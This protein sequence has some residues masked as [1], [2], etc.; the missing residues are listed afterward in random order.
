MRI[1]CLASAMLLALGIGRAWGQ[2]G[3]ATDMPVSVHPATAGHVLPPVKNRDAGGGPRKLWTRGFRVQGVGEHA[4]A[5]I[6]PA[7]M[8]TLAD[9]QFHKLAGEGAAAELS[10]AQLQGAA[11]AI[12]TTYRQAGFIVA[13]AYLPA[14]NVGADQI[15]EIRVLEGQ[16]GKVTVKGTKRYRPE[17][18]AAPAEHLRGRTL[19]KSDVDT[20][21]LYARDLPGIAVSSVLQPGE[22]DGETDLVM[23]ARETPRPYAISVGGNNY[24][25]SLTGRY[26]A[27]VGASWYS[28]LGL[29]DVLSGTYAY[30]LDPRQSHLG[31][32]SY[33]VPTV[34]VPGLSGVIGGSQSSLQ[35]N[36]GELAA[37]KVEGPSSLYYAG[38]DWKFV[39]RENLQMQGTLHAIREESRLS[40]MGMRLSNERFDVAE[41]GFALNRTDVRFHGIDL[42]QVSLRQSISDDSAEP[43]LVS[44]RHARS[45]LVE[46][47]TYTRLQ[48]LTPTQRLYFKFN[49]Q[50]TRA[51]LT[52]LEQFSLGGPDSVRAYPVAQYLSDRGYYASL[53]YHVDAPG[54]A[55]MASPFGRPWR[56]VLELE[57]FIDVARGFAAGANRID[58][59][60]KVPTMRGIGAGFIFRLPGFH[61]FELHLDASRPWGPDRASGARGT[62]VYARLGLTF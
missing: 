5:G 27:Q 49:G 17:V 23:V 1:K 44:P 47:L 36:N 58:A 13:T 9:A 10:F 40:S 4:D 51:A 54:F 24:G 43:D 2:E 6:T 31:S 33:S 52:P 61:Q 26:R 28:P 12:T 50:Y 14:Q 38:A 46:K 62:R 3:A 53:E 59:T 18:V 60:T 42:L 34:V 20:A 41:L 30:A 7:A 35:V 11:D 32:V 29:G 39:N 57:A 16:I 25:T 56:E 37:L 55:S 19:R 21:L 8:Q 45:F 22:N 48:F 15:I